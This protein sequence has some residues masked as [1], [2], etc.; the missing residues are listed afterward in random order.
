MIE[1][2]SI[3]WANPG[4]RCLVLIVQADAFN[5]SRIATV[6]AVPLTDNTHLLGAPG[7]VVIA[8]QEC[9]Q[10][11]PMVA[12]VSRVVTLA[13]DQLEQQVGSV[14]APTLEAIATGLRLALA[15]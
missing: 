1:R 3:W 8:P 2:G 15:L 7:N 6:M 4:E 12:D 14:A 13:R 10:P 9:G 5:R 11:D